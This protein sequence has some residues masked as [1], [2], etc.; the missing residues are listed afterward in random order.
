MTLE[1]DISQRCFEARCAA[2]WWA[3]KCKEMKTEKEIIEEANKR[4]NSFFEREHFI[5][6]AEETFCLIQYRKKQ[7]L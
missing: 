4:Y 2:N 5:R 6:S 1:E 3:A 7:E